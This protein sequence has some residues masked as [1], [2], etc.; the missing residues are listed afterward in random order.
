VRILHHLQGTARGSTLAAVCRMNP[1]ALQMTNVAKPVI[2]PARRST[3]LVKEI[4]LRHFKSYARAG[5]DLMAYA[6]A[7]IR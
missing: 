6:Q 2:R 1:F 4:D 7:V 5:V 3:A